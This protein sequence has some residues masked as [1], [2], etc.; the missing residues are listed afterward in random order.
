[1]GKMQLSR[2]ESLCKSVMLLGSSN[3]HLYSTLF[4]QFAPL[5]ASVDGLPLVRGCEHCIPLI[6]RAKPISVRP[7]RYPPAL[8]T[9]IEQPD[10][11]QLKSLLFPNVVVFKKKDRSWQPVVDYYLNALTI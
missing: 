3:F 11:A 8:K 9:E 4:R 2:S 7:Y 6:R 10:S 1:M 5:F